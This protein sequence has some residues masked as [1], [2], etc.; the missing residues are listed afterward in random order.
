[1][2]DVIVI[3]DEAGYAEARG[4]HK[5]TQ[6]VTESKE[7]VTEGIT[8]AMIF[9]K[10]SALD[11]KQWQIESISRYFLNARNVLFCRKH[12]NP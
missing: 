11:H 7:S 6:Q 1:M 10:L 12:C 2:K 3:I 5:Q 8:P 9:E 4:C